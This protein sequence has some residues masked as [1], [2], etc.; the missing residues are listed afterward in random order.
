MILKILFR[1]KKWC[2]TLFFM[3]KKCR[4]LF[5]LKVLYALHTKSLP[6]PYVDFIFNC[7]NNSTF[8]SES[9]KTEKSFNLHK[10]NGTDRIKQ[11]HPIAADVPIKFPLWQ[12]SNA[13]RSFLHKQTQFCRTN[14]HPQRIVL[15]EFGFII[16]FKICYIR[17]QL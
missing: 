1:F 2:N 6:S 9:Y 12:R 4:R 5:L 3:K 11:T 8:Q 16:S 15:E 13:V 17:I 7:I 10:F 14:L